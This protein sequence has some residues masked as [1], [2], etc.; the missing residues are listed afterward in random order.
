MESTF[1]VEKTHSADGLPLPFSSH[2][3][4]QLGTGTMV[5]AHIHDY[6]ELLY[7]VS[8]DFRIRLGNREHDFHAGDMV[9]I[10]S[11]EIH[12]IDAL[13]EGMHRYI[14]VKFK[15]ELL[16][17]TSQSIF[18][19]KYVMPF[20]LQESSHQKVFPRAEIES[21]P[22]PGLIR[23]IS[24]ECM[25]KAYGYE[26][27][28]KAGILRLFLYILRSWNARSLDL[29]I[30]GSISTEHVRRL[31]QVFEHVDGNFHE[32][33][34]TAEMAE[35][36]H[37]SY[38]YFSRMFKRTMRR[39]FTDYLNFVRISKAEMMLCTTSMNITEIAL[40]SGFSASSYF[41]RQFERYRGISPRQYRKR[42][43]T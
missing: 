21:T 5:R 20:V 11:N 38:S 31:S 30:N 18:E 12:H 39:S 4:T 6:I 2:E 41:I 35:R 1:Y 15:P 3:Q 28:V 43:G 16:Y 27:A 36:C 19:I 42:Y 32:N 9:I 40:A 26:M 25:D 33:I 14:V 22:V 13:S 7:T 29:N 23:D 10:N 34:T 17:A 37:L 24:R 8:G